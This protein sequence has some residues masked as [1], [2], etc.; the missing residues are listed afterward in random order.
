MLPLRG[1]VD[2][3][4]MEGRDTPLFPKLRHYWNLIIRLCSIIFR[5]L[6]GRGSYFSEEK[7][8]V[9]CTAPTYWATGPSLG[10]FYSAAEK[11]LEYSTAPAD[12]ATWDSSHQERSK[13]HSRR[14]K[15]SHFI[16]EATA[17]VTY[18]PL[19]CGLVWEFQNRIW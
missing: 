7:Q 17:S 11:K 9:N 10:E 8:P 2:M 16:A 4:A 1:K 12:W 14:K 13:A 18:W 19:T 15:N 3:E 5:T 6:V